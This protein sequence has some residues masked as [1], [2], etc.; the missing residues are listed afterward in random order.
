[1]PEIDYEKLGRSVAEHLR[2]RPCSLG[3]TQ[4]DGETLR[5]FA[6][7]LRNAKA[8][9]IG[10]LVK[11]LLLGAIGMMLAGFWDKVRSK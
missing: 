10:V 3:M 9:A 1:M 11:I 7:S 2:Q 5:E 4:A 8:T 6:A